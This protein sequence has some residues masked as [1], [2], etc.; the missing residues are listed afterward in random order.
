[1][2]Y[3]RRLLLEKVCEIQRITLEHTKRGV[4]Q[5]YVYENYVKDQFFI[6]R[7]TY[8]NYLEMPAKRELTLLKQ[9]Q[10]PEPAKA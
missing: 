8:Y 3:N 6:S 10:L 7:S 9:K 1:M 5:K 2:A 4:T